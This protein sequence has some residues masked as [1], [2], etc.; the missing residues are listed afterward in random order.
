MSKPMKKE[1]SGH[2]IEFRRA[3]PDE[4]EA[5]SLLIR[6]AF[7][8]FESQYTADAFGY[9]TP[10]ADVIRERFAEGPVWAAFENDV[11]VGTVSGLPEPDRFYIRSM[12]IKPSAQRAGIG[13]KLLET[14]EAF[15]R[16]E[17]HTKLY[18]YTT[19]VLPGA[20]RLYEKNGFYVLRETSPEEWYDMGGLEMEKKLD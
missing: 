14:L 17:G 2:E 4:A 8:P 11:M 12:A 20:Q 10:S 18:L 9:T 3:V 5:I 1:V 13:Q 6:E 16:K 7:G 19:F 15:A